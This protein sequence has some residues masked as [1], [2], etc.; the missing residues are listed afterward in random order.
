MH[1]EGEFYSV[2]DWGEDLPGR[3]DVGRCA[4]EAIL[5]AASWGRRIATGVGDGGLLVTPSGPERVVFD[6]KPVSGL[7]YFTYAGERYFENVDHMVCTCLIAGGG[8]RCE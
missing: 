7:D 5:G 4:R 3:K 8:G 2:Y 1:F 6:S